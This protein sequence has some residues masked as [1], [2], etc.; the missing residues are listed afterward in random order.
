MLLV[1]GGLMIWLGS[2]THHSVATVFGIL[3]AVLGLAGLRVRSWMRRERLLRELGE[4]FH[5]PEE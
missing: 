1:S 4:G 5:V 2:T 3:A